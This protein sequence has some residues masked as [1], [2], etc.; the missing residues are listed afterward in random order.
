MSI[1]TI[2]ELGRIQD[3]VRG[4]SDERLPVLSNCYC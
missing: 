1:T 4:S 2:D 3:L